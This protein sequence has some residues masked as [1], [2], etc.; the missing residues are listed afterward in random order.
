LSCHHNPL[1][2]SIYS[3][4][5]IRGNKG[6]YS[7]SNKSNGIKIGLQFYN[8]WQIH[9]HQLNSSQLRLNRL[10]RESGT[11]DCIATK[12]VYDIRQRE[13]KLDKIKCQFTAMSKVLRIEDCKLKNPFLL[14]G[15][16]AQYLG[17]DK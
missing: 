8:L 5:I 16:L 2:S 9:G 3:S 4:E 15:P 12:D 1:Q 17:S 6:L 13:E 7:D 10:F 11:T 14:F